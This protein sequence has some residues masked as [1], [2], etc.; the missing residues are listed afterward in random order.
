[1]KRSDL[2]R[3]LESHGC[4][5]VAEG[6]SHSIYAARDGKRM[7][8]VPRHREVNNFTARNICK[9]LAIPPPARR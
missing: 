4:R 3:Y 7:T 1:M 6:G 9:D 2:V 8:A 5:L